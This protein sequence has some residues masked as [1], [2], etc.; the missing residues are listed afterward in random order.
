M[1]TAVPR[2][3]VPNIWHIVGPMVERAIDYEGRRTDAISVYASLLT[4]ELGLWVAL[5]DEGIIGCTVTRLYDAPLCRVLSLDYTAG[6]NV[7]TWLDEGAEV[8]NR[9]AYDHGAEFMECRG[10]RGWEPRL[11]K[12]GWDNKAVLYERAVTV[13]E[14]R[15]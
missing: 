7:D 9:Y 2:Q 12:Y 15:K 6:D 5:S 13:P 4:G 1:I 8:L 3:E 14:R 11:R 10:R